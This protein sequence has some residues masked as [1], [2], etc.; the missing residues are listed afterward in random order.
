MRLR[1]LSVKKKFIY[2]LI[3]FM[4]LPTCVIS[5]WMYRNVSNSWIQKEY[6]IQ[7]N[8]I[9]N[10]LRT[11]EMWLEDYEDILY[12]AYIETNMMM[13]LNKSY[14]ERSTHSFRSV[15]KCM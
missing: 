9:G 15:K 12:D 5:L 7:S 3:L 8:E 4:L 14:H 11:T 2:I 13:N 1:N 6:S 10:I